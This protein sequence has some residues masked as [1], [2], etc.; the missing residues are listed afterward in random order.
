MIKSILLKL[1]LE[2]CFLNLKSGK[3]VFQKF[4]Q[5]LRK[6]NENLC[7]HKNLQT[8][9]YN[10]LIHYSKILK[11]TQSSFSG[12]TA[13]HTLAHLYSGTP[14]HKEEQ[15]ANN[16]PGILDGPQGHDAQWERSLYMLHDSVQVTFLKWQ[17]S[18]EGN[19]WTVSRDRAGSR[20]WRFVRGEGVGVNTERPHEWG[21]SSAVMKQ[22]CLTVAVVT[23]TYTCDKT[24]CTRTHTHARGM[25]YGENQVTSVGPVTACRGVGSLVLSSHCSSTRRHHRGNWTSALRALH[26]T[27]AAASGKSLSVST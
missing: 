6:R 17:N 7:S 24:A 11:I 16:T 13:E 19:Y 27:V 9:I 20:R 18:R 3:P 5:S 15:W 12:W 14:L 25:K 26:R 10:G 22:P 4:I 8:K 1:C 21:S 23:W 2:V